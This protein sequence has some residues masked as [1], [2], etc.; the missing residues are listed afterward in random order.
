VPL[1][2]RQLAYPSRIFKTQKRTL[3]M[4]ESGAKSRKAWK[5]KL[6]FSTEQLRSSHPRSVLHGD[7][8]DKTRNSARGGVDSQENSPRRTIGWSFN[9]PDG[10]ITKESVPRSKVNEPRPSF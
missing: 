9:L 8:V 7:A 3:S 1:H 2:V 5:T 4:A 6:S 10:P